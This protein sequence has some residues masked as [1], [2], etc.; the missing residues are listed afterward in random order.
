MSN[1]KVINVDTISRCHTYLLTI[2][3][4][5]K[6]GA[7]LSQKDEIDAATLLDDIR[8]KSEEYVKA[9]KKELPLSLKN[10]EIS[11]HIARAEYS[12]SKTYFINPVD[13]KK[14][15]NIQQFLECIKVQMKKAKEILPEQKVKEIS[16][17]GEPI[18][19]V[20]LKLVKK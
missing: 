7:K 13:L 5:L 11:G 4:G 16:Q 14:E 10:K 3:K 8:K 19:R 12:E 17:L 18:P 9:L 20:T 1:G 6:E 2:I 15:T